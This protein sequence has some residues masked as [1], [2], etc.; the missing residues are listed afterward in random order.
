MISLVS[1]K[2]QSS[3]AGQSRDSGAGGSILVATL[4]GGLM[5]RV[6]IALLAIFLKIKNFKPGT[7]AW[8]VD[9]LYYIS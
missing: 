7:G 8:G 9:S 1:K 5:I 6:I 4:Q 2:E 3:N